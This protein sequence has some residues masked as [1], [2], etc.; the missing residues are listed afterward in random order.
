MT[1]VRSAVYKSSYLLTYLLTYLHYKAL[2]TNVLLSLLYMTEGTGPCNSLIIVACQDM[3]PGTKVSRFTSGP[4]HQ[5]VSP[6][7]T[8]AM[9][10]ISLVVAGTLFDSG[11]A[12]VNRYIKRPAIS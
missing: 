3:K 9:G 1:L 11:D 6:G 2:Y 4:W 8:A 10:P 5:Y 7:V 12:T